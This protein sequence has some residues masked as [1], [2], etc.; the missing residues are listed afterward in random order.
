MSNRI[1]SPFDV[2]RC[3]LLVVGCWPDNPR[4]GKPG[5]QLTTN[6]QQ[7]STSLAA[8]ICLICCAAMWGQTDTATLSGRVTDASGGVMVGADVTLTNTATGTSNQMKTNE[9]GVYSF[10]ALLPGPYRL[11]VR[12]AGFQ[13]AVREGLN[14]HVQDRI[15]QD[16]SLAVGSSDQKVVAAPWSAAILWRICR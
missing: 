11:A 1:V 16:I 6:N 4:V 14:L 8:L 3:W 12:A 2:E 9:S 15:G 5:Q 13:Q 10:S 7:R